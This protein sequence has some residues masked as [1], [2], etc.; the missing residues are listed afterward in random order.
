MD[1]TYRVVYGVVVVVLT[2]GSFVVVVVTGGSL[3]V[4]VVVTGGSFVVVTGGSVVVFVT[5]GSVV[6]VVTGGLVVVTGGLLVVVVTG[7]SAVVTGGSLVVTGGSTDDMVVVVPVGGES[8]VVVG[9]SV[10]VIGAAL[11]V[12]ASEDLVS[13]V[14]FG[15]STV[16][17]E[18]GF[19]GV[20]GA[21]VGSGEVVEPEALVAIEHYPQEVVMSW[22]LIAG[23][24]EEVCRSPCFEKGNKRKLVKERKNEAID[25]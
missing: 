7:G 2:G 1:V 16:G 18:E 23:K 24:E 10:A 9:L 19:E 22:I 13:V 14:V 20:R 5:G 8:V 3:V 11:V 6:V 4:V 12:V 25:T 15:G 21:D 17:C